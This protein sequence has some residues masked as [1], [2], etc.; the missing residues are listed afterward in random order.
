MKYVS[1]YKIEK[2]VNQGNVNPQLFLGENLNKTKT[3]KQTSQKKK[4]K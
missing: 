3:G 1:L 4:V 2:Q